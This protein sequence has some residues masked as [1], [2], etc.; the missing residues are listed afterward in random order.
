MEKIIEQIV[1]NGWIVLIDDARRSGHVEKDSVST[2]LIRA[3]DL[4]KRERFYERISGW[5]EQSMKRSLDAI[6]TK[7]E[8]YYESTNKK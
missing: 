2:C 4:Q 5:D 3:E 1:A 6:L 8:N 7:I